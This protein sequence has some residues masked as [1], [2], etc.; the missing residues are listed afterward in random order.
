MAVQDF[1]VTAI[2][3]ACAVVVVAL[4]YLGFIKFTDW[5]SWK[6]YNKSHPL[7]PAMPKEWYGTAK[8]LD[9]I[10][11]AMGPAIE[12]EVRRAKLKIER[13]ESI[14]TVPGLP[15]YGCPELK[16]FFHEVRGCVMC[17]FKMAQELKELREYKEKKEKEE[18][19]A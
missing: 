18:K 10:Q 1:I 5:C 9:D 12:A 14:F 3:W 17:P 19:H 11:S 4:I 2:A 13:G 16:D 8:S 15:C 7:P 6:D